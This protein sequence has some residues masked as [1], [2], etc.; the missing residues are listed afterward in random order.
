MA[1]WAFWRAK[2]H[3]GHNFIEDDRQM[4]LLQRQSKAEI[5]RLETE[6]KKNEMQLAHEKKKIE[7]ECAIEEDRQRLAD[8]R[9]ENDEDDDDDESSMNNTLMSLFAPL[10]QQGAAGVP[11]QAAPS[12]DS[13]ASAQT[14]NSQQQEAHPPTFTDEQIR[15]L[16]MQLPKGQLAIAKTLDDNTLVGLVRSRMPG[17]DERTIMRGIEILRE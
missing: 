4:S 9:G 17:L 6:L 7:M 15:G 8:L 10:L 11:Q 14:V 3:G 12:W 1:W 2:Q 16:L 5:V 13:P